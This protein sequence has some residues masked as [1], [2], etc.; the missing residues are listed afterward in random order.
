MLA[1]RLPTAEAVDIYIPLPADHPCQRVLEQNLDANLPEDI[2]IEER[3]GNRAMHLNY[4]ICPH[5]EVGGKPWR[6][7][8]ETAFSYRE[9]TP[10]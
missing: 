9:V 8:L 1:P 5:V 7:E 3:H 2:G 6:A 10:G 4:F